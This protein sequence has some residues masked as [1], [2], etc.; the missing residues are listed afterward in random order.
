MKLYDFYS[1]ERLCELRERMGA[2]LTGGFVNAK[3]IM[4]MSPEEIRKLGTE[5]IEGELGDIHVE[6]DGT[7]SLKGQRVV[8]YIRDIAMYKEDYKM[9]KFHVSY[10]KTLEE[11]SNKN[12]FNLRYVFYQ[13]DSGTFPINLIKDKR[14][15]SKSIPLNV[16]MFCMGRIDWN[17][18]QSNR[19]DKIARQQIVKDFTLKKFYERYPKDLLTVLPQYSAALSPIN[20]YTQDWNLVRDRIKRER[21]FKC[22]RCS[23]TRRDRLDV[24]HKNGQKNDNTKSNLE[25]LCVTCHME[26]HA[27]YNG[28]SF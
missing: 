7:L 9:P 10:C 20:D 18:F 25:V 6:P 22:E 26:E 13:N 15:E 11:K 23:E 27:H 3:P 12:Q 21:N 24:H 5:G 19:N 14:I 17:G 16:C 8:V 2:K 1:D 4:L 28:R